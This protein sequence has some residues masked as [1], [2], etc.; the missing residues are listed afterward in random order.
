M[1][2]L[3]L[4]GCGGEVH[5]VAAAASPSPSTA[6]TPEPP[7]PTPVP[8]PTPLVPARPP[9]HF[10]I[11]SLGIDA[12]VE[13]VPFLGVP[14]DPAKVAWF[15]TGPAPGEP[16]DAVIDGHLDWTTGPA[17]FW[18]LR[19][20]KAGAEIDITGG[21]GQKVV[22]TVDHVDVVD[23]NSNP[24]AWLYTETGDPSLSLITCEGTY[25]RARGYNE[26]LLVHSVLATAAT[27]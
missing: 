23:A 27:S 12:G 19:D 10:A 3:A 13:Q 26:R 21:D 25:S 1:L 15:R 5:R 11:P 24:P 7:T 17:V 6:P 22:F 20:I 9:V 18:H 14:Q 16:G 8:T 2:S 4:Q